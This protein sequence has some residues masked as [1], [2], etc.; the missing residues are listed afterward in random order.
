MQS[1][2]SSASLV[3]G[4]PMALVMLTRLLVQ[5]VGVTVECSTEMSKACKSVFRHAHR[6][7]LSL[8]LCLHVYTIDR[9]TGHEKNYLFMFIIP[10]FS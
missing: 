6:A 1:L 7:P 8:L 3:D 5:D 9:C 4:L 10:I 2:A